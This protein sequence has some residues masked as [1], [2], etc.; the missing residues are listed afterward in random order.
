MLAATILI[1]LLTA[2]AYGLMLIMSGRA[3]F[4]YIGAA[5]ATSMAVNAWR[6]ISPVQRRI[7]LALAAGKQEPADAVRLAR[8]RAAHNDAL[9]IAVLFF[10]VS[11]HFPLVYGSGWRWLLA[12]G[13]V[14]AGWI[15][16]KGISLL[17]ASPRAA[18]V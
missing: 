12:G 14:I 2:L 16:A 6:H 8:Q 5:L 11:N 1:V 7:R 18:R 15:I 9:S 4:L 13:F 3:L 17:L 10:M